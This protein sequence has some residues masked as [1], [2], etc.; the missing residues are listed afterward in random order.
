MEPP[1]EATIVLTFGF[2]SHWLR[3]DGTRIADLRT[4][5]YSI[6]HDPA[7]TPVLN[8]EEIRRYADLGASLLPEAAQDQAVWYARKLVETRGAGMPQH[9]ICRMAEEITDDIPRYRLEFREPFVKM[10]EEFAP[11]LPMDDGCERLAAGALLFGRADDALVLA[12]ALED[13]GEMG[14]AAWWRGWADRQRTAGQEPG[15]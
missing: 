12:D 3:P 7:V 13:L 1:I 8:L 15:R 14:D 4:W 6:I 5:G 11:V 10:R 9:T 2:R